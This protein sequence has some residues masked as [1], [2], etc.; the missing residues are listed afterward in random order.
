MELN[1][2]RKALST[3]EQYATMAIITI[4]TTENTI[5]RTNIICETLSNITFHFILF[6]SFFLFDFS[7]SWIYP[8]RIDVL[9]FDFI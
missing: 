5:R 7:Y 8:T 2:Q 6:L 9:S 3:R 4:T 1:P